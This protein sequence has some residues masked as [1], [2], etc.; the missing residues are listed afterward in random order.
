[1]NELLKNEYLAVSDVAGYLCISTSKV[2]QLVKRP[3]FSICRL[4][5]VIRIPR[6]AFLCWLA[7]H[8]STTGGNG[9]N[10]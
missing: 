2:Y 5:G 4:G 3:D 9:G 6:D 7:Q 10:K 1:M 8:T